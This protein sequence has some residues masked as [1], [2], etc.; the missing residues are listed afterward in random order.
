MLFLGTGGHV[1]PGFDLFLDWLAKMQEPFEHH[2]TSVSSLC[3]ENFNQGMASST[4][5]K[6]NA[7]PVPQSGRIFSKYR[8]FLLG[9]QKVIFECELQLEF[10]GEEQEA[11][12]GMDVS[13]ATCI[14]MARN[15]QHLW[16]YL[17]SS[18]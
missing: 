2:L 10:E 14:T 3:F 4:V 15:D 6:L 13:C 9:S 7:A 16:L 18:C 11:L 12:K 1:R 17:T 5:I 8:N